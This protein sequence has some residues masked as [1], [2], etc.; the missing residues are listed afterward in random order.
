MNPTCLFHFFIQAKLVILLLMAVCQLCW[1]AGGIVTDGTVGP[2]KSFIG[3]NV[4]IPENF[5]SRH[6][7][8]LFHSFAEF[9]IKNNQA[10]TFKDNENTRTDN[11][12]SRVT[13]GS[14]SNINGALNVSTGDKTNFYLI[15]PNGIIMGSGSE[16]NVPGSIHL[17]TA[18]TIKL[19]D[20]NVYSAV[21]PQ[22]AANTLS[23]A[24]PAAFGFLG[25]STKN[26]GLF[27]MD[28]SKLFSFNNV[29]TFDVVAGKILIQKGE[30]NSFNLDSDVEL[31]LIS[32]KGT[33]EISLETN[34]YGHL[35]LPPEKLKPNLNGG[36]ILITEGNFL[37][38]GNGTGKVGVWGGKVILTQ[39][40]N[41]GLTNFGDNNPAADNGVF[42]TAESL[43]LQNNSRIFSQN[44]I[45]SGQSADINLKVIGTIKVDNGSNVQT[46]S[47]DLSDAGN[48]TIYAGQDIIIQGAAAKILS[49]ITH[50]ASVSKFPKS[51]DIKMEAGNDIKLL[52]GGSIIERSQAI[53]GRLGKVELITKNL[54]ID[55]ANAIPDSP[56]GIFTETEKSV[57][58]GNSADLA[59]DINIWL[60]GHLS[61]LNGSEISSSTRSEGSSGNI[62]IK[63][64][65]ITIKNSRIKA[66]SRIGDSG[67]AGNISLT[68]SND[69]MIDN[70]EVSVLSKSLKNNVEGSV[71]LH[72]KDNLL[73]KSSKI[74]TESNS[75]NGGGITLTGDN[76]VMETAFIQANSQGLNT[77]GGTINLNIENLLA[78]G[79]QLT[80]GGR[81]P[82]TNW[83]SNRFGFNVIQSAAPNGVNGL[84]NISAPAL[85]L[86]GTLA[87]L[88]TPR[89]DTG[90]L[91]WDDCSTGTAAF[92]IKL[93][94]NKDL[95]NEFNF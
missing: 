33:A 12:I 71:R 25:S 85:N 54:I 47:S 21:N 10:V 76:V 5:G 7:G 28:S 44:S 20:G 4:D 74:V 32:L 67:S 90:A 59:G 48:I 89:F 30:I 65:G 55:N 83:E 68:S 78:S 26:N 36:D 37:L 88:G 29:K 61:M 23:N 35:N 75:G 34:K 58:T 8:N 69:I 86:S 94:N 43:N 84:I 95:P 27:K 56:T 73:L 3:S 50:S 82:L 45:D 6:G 62:S 18:D 51:G 87:S 70:G 13:G 60:R 19:K 52:S 53:D 72:F 91:N 40:S 81:T 79:N 92:S 22:P 9:N 16:V 42:L 64:D 93:L 31:R 15:N 14:N 41:L 1:A 49:S 24:P 17:S 80:L 39:G 2:V 11:I 77:K 63:A 57:F 38:N 46:E 66:E